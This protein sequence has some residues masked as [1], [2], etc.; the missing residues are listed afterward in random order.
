M[1]SQPPRLTL[2][3]KLVVFILIAGCFYGAY[4]FLFQKSTPTIRTPL[5]PASQ[6][7][8]FSAPSSNNSTV[9]EFGIA[10]GTEKENWLKWSVEQ[11]KQVAPNIKVNLIPMGS[12]EAAKSIISGNQKIHV[13]SPASSLYKEMFIQDWQAKY[14]TQ[15][16]IIK[17]EILALTPMVIVMWNDRYKAFMQHYSQVDFTTISQ[18]LQEPT[19]WAA[20]ANKPEWGLFKFGQTHPLQSNSGLATLILMAYD[21][22]KKCKKLSVAN[23]IDAG[24][25]KWLR[26]FARS[27]SGLNNSTGNLV[28]DMILK[29]PSMYDAVFVYENTAIDYLKSAQGRWGSLSVVYPSHNLWNDNPYY[30]LDVN[31]SGAEQR[32]A[33]EAFLQFLLSE[34]VQKQ[35]LVHGFRPGNVQIPVNDAQSP[36]MQNQATGL[37]IDINAVC[38]IPDDEVITNLMNTWQ[39]SQIN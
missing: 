12:L 18:A 2:L 36:F 6:S 37:K 9:V 20:I 4:Y 8:P 21:Y 35:A 5:L 16:P 15:N 22:Q 33:A 14:S 38:D 25:Q 1:D 30:I 11:F 10:Y 17:E 19:G 29:G 28:R 24:F 23:I 34:N 26:D 3:G 13:W 7:H 39:R 32:E 31:W 27:V